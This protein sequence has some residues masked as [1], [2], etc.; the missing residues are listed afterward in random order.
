MLNNVTKC[1]RDLSDSYYDHARV[2]LKLLCEGDQIT[3]IIKYYDGV[4]KKRGTCTVTVNSNNEKKSCNSRV[5]SYKT[6][7]SHFNNEI[8]MVSIDVRLFTEI[9]KDSDFLKV[10]KEYH[11][12]EVI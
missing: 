5:N 11:N 9:E 7:A 8:F 4:I 2:L 6:S 3:H 12:N 1:I 10:L